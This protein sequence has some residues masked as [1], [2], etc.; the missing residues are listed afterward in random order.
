MDILRLTPIEFIFITIPE[1]FL[2]VFS[3]YVL[4]KAKFDFKRYF[5]SVVLLS[6]SVYLIR[7]LPISYGIHTILNIIILVGLGIEINKI[8]M[9]DT[10]RAAIIAA[11][12]LFLSEGLDLGIMKVFAENINYIFNN[13]ILKIIWGFP[14]LIIF[15][16]LILLIKK[17]GDKF[18]N[19]KCRKNIE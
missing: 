15:V 1:S 16:I 7:L 4:T 10:V 9:I 6:F 8:D 12:V 17:L 14:S 3:L 2:L 5:T 11:V 19:A 13:E 18:I